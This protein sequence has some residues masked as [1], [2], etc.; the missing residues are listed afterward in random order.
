MQELINEFNVAM[1]DKDIFLAWQNEMRLRQQIRTNAGR[2]MIRIETSDEFK[3]LQRC[4]FYGPEQDVFFDIVYRNIA[5]L[6]ILNCTL[7]ASPDLISGFFD[8]L[9]RNIVAFKPP[10]RDLQFLLTMYREEFRPYF[11]EIINN[12]DAELC[13]HLLARTSNKD[14]RKLLKHG[15]EHTTRDERPEHYGLIDR[16]VPLDKYP[17]I[18]GDKIQIMAAAVNAL[19]AGQNYNLSS[20]PLNRESVNTLLDSADMLFRAGLLSDCL[21]ILTKMVN[22]PGMDEQSLLLSSEEPFCQQINGLLRKVLPIYS[23]LASPTDSHRY[24]L[25]LYRSLFPGFSPDPA[26]LLYLDIHTIVMASLQGHRQY[27]RYELA[28]K[29]GKIQ[30]FRPD[31]SVASILLKS[32]NVITLE[33]YS[34]LEQAIKQRIVHYPHEVYIIMEVLRLWHS[35]GRMTFNRETAANLLNHY[36]RFFAWIPAKPFMNEQVQSQLGL[37]ADE[38]TRSAGERILMVIQEMPQSTNSDSE[39]YKLRQQLLLGKFMGV[40]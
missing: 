27:A 11:I 20:T 4:L 29:A 7:Q 21:A 9:A 26:S 15:Q 35:E 5:S 18:F 12:M 25:E 16:A 34:G 19:T 33:E 14:L 40:F 23:L 3:F 1:S 30:G 39:V 24:V 32:K 10:A 22:R 2:E 37:L 6:T 31:D 28:Q 38:E 17:T 36:L 13:G 8:Y